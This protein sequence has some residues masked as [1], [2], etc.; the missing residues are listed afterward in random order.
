MGTHATSKKNGLGHVGI[1][2]CD[3]PKFERVEVGVSKGFC[4]GKEGGFEKTI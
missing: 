1:R 4:M 2:R 3:M